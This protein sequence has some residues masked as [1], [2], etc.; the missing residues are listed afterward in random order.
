[1]RV[2]WSQK[3]SVFALGLLGSLTVSCGKLQTQDQSSL[4]VTNGTEISNSEFPA[5][6]LLY[7][8]KVGSICTGT[9]VTETI[10]LT[11]AHCTM[12]GELGENGVVDHEL[13]IIELDKSEE[14]SAKLVATSSKVI[15]NPLWDAAG[16]NVNR[17][18]LGLVFFEPGVSKGIRRISRDP[19]EVGDEFTIVGFG[20]N[21]SNPSDS[22]SAGIKR[23]GVNLVSEVSGGFLQ[24]VGKNKTTNGD[25]SDVAAGSGDS[26]G[27]LL[28]NGEIAGVTSGGG[29]GGFGRTRSLYIDIHSDTSRE[30]LSEYLN[31]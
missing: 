21:T 24:F 23:K 26:G 6:V 22:S 8:E 20:L 1:M 3:Y 15:R 10:V 12:G 5:V 27:P 4:K 7:D 17:Y 2:Q 30:F 25:G 9:F 11:A 31:Y 16:R 19:A 14:K 13:K 18:D 29:W 28:I